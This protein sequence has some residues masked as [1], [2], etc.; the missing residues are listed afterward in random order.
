MKKSL[1]FWFAAATCAAWIL[2]GC[3]QEPET[4][5]EYVKSGT[6]YGAVTAAELQTAIDAAVADGRTLELS[7]ITLTAGSVNLKT[8]SVKIAGTL[9]LGN[10]AIIA[11]AEANVTF[12]DDAT[13]SGDATNV[14]VGDPTVFTTAKAPGVVVVEP[15]A[16]GTLPTTG[17][18]TAVKDLTLTA[19]AGDVI[20]GLTVYVYGTLTVDAASVA[21]TGTVKAIG[22][23]S[24]SGTNS[25]ALAGATVDIAGA[26][27]TNSAAAEVTLPADVAVKAIA[28]GSTD[29]TITGV[30]TGLTVGS[31]TNGGGNL[32][33]ATASSIIKQAGDDDA[34]F[35]FGAANQVLV[36]PALADSTLTLGGA[37]TL[38][39]A[40]SL[41]D[42]A[43]V[44]LGA[45]AT[46]ITAA[47]DAI[48]VG[49]SGGTF[50]PTGAGVTFPAGTEFDGATK[51][52]T[53]GS[54]GITIGGS[55]T[56][57]EVNKSGI[58]KGKIVLDNTT[59]SVTL[60]KAVITGA[61]SAAV[62]FTKSGAV[63]G[64]AAGTSLAL[65]DEGAIT[66]AGGGKVTAGATEFSGVG[67]WTAS[68]TGT[69]GAATVDI[70][71][72]ATGATIAFNANNG[73]AT[74][75][76]LTASGTNP[77]ITQDDG[78]GNELVIGANTE[79][80]LGGEGAVVGSIVLTGASSDP[81]KLTF[82]AYGSS[83]VGTSLVTTG[84]S[85][86]TTKVTGLTTVA[87]KGVGVTIVGYFDNSAAASATKV[88]KLGASNETNS[89]VGGGDNNNATISG[90]T[91][92]AGDF[93][94][95]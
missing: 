45:S 7:G 39:G 75:G 41:G 14:I 53:L 93:G 80:A 25:V 21:P 29:L 67:T 65:E 23:V 62:T 10:N 24:V 17:G 72:A 73:N 61:A 11:A 81:G 58:L 79:I 28:V 8:A 91:Y 59:D 48:T 34:T 71:S 51:T 49:D 74:A 83:D 15:A 52:V 87:D 40:L 3:E 26:T 13:V 27:L 22:T 64:L 86:A 85:A 12:A 78:S 5:T 6:V 92:T 77:T 89:I 1:I 57:F 16:G 55:T 36:K 20:S 56:T 43:K 76:A 9:T 90:Q 66:T 19:T 30:S 88:F 46:L 95:A 38:V 50:T 63:V 42:T 70:T 54:A 44:E 37:T 82:T 69:A 31:I 33:L 18:V 68:F 32:K 60:D 2:V 84:N 94:S 4:K 35:T 47:S